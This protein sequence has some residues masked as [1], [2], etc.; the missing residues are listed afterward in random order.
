VRVRVE[1][2]TFSSN[3]DGRQD[4]VACYHYSSNIRVFEF[5]QNT[6]S[7]RLQLVLEDDE[8]DEIQIPLNFSASHLLGSDP[9]QPIEMSRSA[10]DNTVT[11]MSVV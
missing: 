11:L 1:K 6:R 5:F 4:V 10:A 8:T 9:A 2:T 3:T 7:A